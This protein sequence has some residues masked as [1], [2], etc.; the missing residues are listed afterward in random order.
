MVKPPIVYIAGLLRAR[1]RG[2][3]ATTGPGS[4]TSPASAS[5]ARRTSPAGT[6]TRWLDTSTFRGRWIAANEIAGDDV[7]DDEAAYDAE[8]DGR[9]TAVDKALRFWGEPD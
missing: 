6:R 3:A 4:P 2:I 9:R 7:I 1:R 5:S 8:R